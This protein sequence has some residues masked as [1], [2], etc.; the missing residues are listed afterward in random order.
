MSYT[1]DTA[2]YPIGR[3]KISYI[4]EEMEPEAQDGVH[5]A[6]NFE[7]L[8]DAQTA[9]FF[10]MGQNGHRYAYRLYMTIDVLPVAT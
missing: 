7:T 6:W 2:N 5:C 1:P 9:L 8:A 3:H 4:L 10:E